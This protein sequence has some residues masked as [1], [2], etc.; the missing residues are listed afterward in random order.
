MNIVNVFRKPLFFSVI[1]ILMIPAAFGQFKTDR[2][3]ELESILMAPCLGGGTLAE[4]DE[5]THPLTRKM[6]STT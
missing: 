3:K 2:Q 4:P 6:T 5:H 1:V